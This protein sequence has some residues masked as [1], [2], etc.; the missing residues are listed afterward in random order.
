MTLNGNS[1]GRKLIGD[2]WV[3]LSAEIGG[4]LF[5]DITVG[6]DN[7]LY[8]KYT[9]AYGYGFKVKK[10]TNGFVNAG[11]LEDV[12]GSPA[13]GG[14]AVAADGT[15]YAAYAALKNKNKISEKIGCGQMGTSRHQRI[16]QSRCS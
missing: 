11:D 6:P 3:K 2:N 1:I 12:A 4:A 7:L 9:A 14:I 5:P 15:L 13:S 10:I 16:E 8:L